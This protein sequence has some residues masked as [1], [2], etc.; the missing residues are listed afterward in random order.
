MSSLY[1]I[2]YNKVDVKAVFPTRVIYIDFD[3]NRFDKDA[4]YGSSVVNGVVFDFL[5]VQNGVAYM[6]RALKVAE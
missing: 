5:V 3:E 6:I 4:V 2:L 1:C